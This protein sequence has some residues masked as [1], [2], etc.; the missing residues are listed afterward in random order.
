MNHHYSPKQS[1]RR[2]RF[3]VDTFLRPATLRKIADL[4][5]ADGRSGHEGFPLRWGRPWEV[6]T[7]SL[8]VVVPD[9][10]DE[11]AEGLEL[12]F[13][14]GG[15]TH[16]HGFSAEA[17][18][19]VN[20][21]IIG[22][23]SATH[24]DI[25]L[26]SADRSPGETLRID[27]ELS[28]NPTIHRGMDRSRRPPA[29]VEMYLFRSAELF[30][31][32]RRV[33]RA[34]A[35][36]A[37]LCDLVE[38]SSGALRE[39]LNAKL[40]LA[41]NRIDLRDPVPSIAAAAEWLHGNVA[42]RLSQFE[43]SVHLVGH[44]HIDTA[45]LWPLAEGERKVARTFAKALTMMAA[46]EDFRYSA[47]QALHYHWI[48]RSDPDLFEGIRKAVADGSWEPIG[49]MWVEPDLEIPSGESLIR[50][51]Q[52]GKRYFLDKFG[53]ET[54]DLWAV[55]A[56]G[57]PGNLPQIL[58]LA[59]IRLCVSAKFDFNDTNAFPHHTFRWRGI[60]G[61]EV[62]AHFVPSGTNHGDLKASSL[63]QSVAAYREHGRSDASVYIY[64]DGNGGGGPTEEM[65]E[66]VELF[67]SIVKPEG[68]ATTSLVSR[69]WTAL[70]ESPAD[71]L[72]VWHGELYGEMHRGVYT[73]DVELKQWHAHCEVLLDVVERLS[74]LVM[75]EA[76]L[77]MDEAWRRLLTC[78]FHDIITGVAI[79]EANGEAVADLT[80]LS[81]ELATGV[82][83]LLDGTHPPDRIVNV[84]PF[85]RLEVVRACPPGPGH[86]R[87]PSGE[88]ATAPLIAVRVPALS[89]VPLTDAI[90]EPAHR[91]RVE[92]GSR[93]MSNGV[94]QLTWDK[95][96]AI[97]TIG[98]TDSPGGADVPV[99]TALMT[100]VDVPVKRDAW[101]V[102]TEYADYPA[103]RF[104]PA[105]APVV[106]TGP[107]HCALEFSGEI[108][109]AAAGLR[110]ELRSHTPEVRVEI[111]VDWRR[112]HRLLQFGLSVGTGW[113]FTRSTQ[114]GHVS[115]PADPNSRAEQA[116]FEVCANTWSA[117]Q[118]DSHGIA[119]ITA[120]NYGVSYREGRY[121][122]SLLRAP[123]DPSD[124]VDRGVRK[125]VFHLHPY[126]GPGF[127]EV[128]RVAER[129]RL[130]LLF[131]GSG[132]SR[133][134]FSFTLEHP[135]IQVSAIYR[136]PGTDSIIVRLWEAQGKTGSTG[137]VFRR[138]PA[139]CFEVDLLDRPL[140]NVEVARG[141]V[142]A[143]FQ[144]FQIRT[145]RFDFS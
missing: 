142:R 31:S 61:S 49:S 47:S 97:R 84:S 3:L 113:R 131:G 34:R 130:P 125:L 14:I 21:R 66:R 5:F 23:V 38:Q 48:E 86:L 112:S 59:G 72:P 82:S 2:T 65:L 17:T 136:T 30:A 120:G 119:L 118:D 6:C 67:R 134:D 50:Q 87:P 39:Y 10:W 43:H 76:P 106:S 103:G 89:S 52:H 62:L 22:G 9:S 53:V 77:A 116:R 69:Y 135:E 44:S 40:S 139:A 57:L 13:D 85:D 126:R 75:R 122:L 41:L 27:L 25:W 63:L 96:G 12:H 15:S 64:G 123:E 11:A 26:T 115:H 51:I 128:V 99:R 90:L 16:R 56:F 108:D 109:G 1:L 104:T 58:A 73:T 32:N 144:P 46:F 91:C 29:D 127:S 24:P 70:A 79:A 71:A 36:F 19:F 28:A 83:D 129:L 95:D 20:S 102:D 18:V 37:I 114:F 8:E 100:F 93:T 140:Q 42:F 78:Q 132:S 94:T 45:Y 141:V 33:R 35:V 68:T 105:G 74:A 92:A 88:V 98:R 138:A 80:R 107:D 143:E 81:E 54:R 7:E 137:I 145:Y 4:S 133:L 124:Q 121:A 111:T 101:D 110:Y 55:D 60:N 117:V